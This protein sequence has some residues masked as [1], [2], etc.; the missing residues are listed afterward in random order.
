MSR[1]VLVLLLIAVGL[2]LYLWLVEMPTEQKRVETATATKK[3]VNF[4]E[5]DV[6]ALTIISSQGEVELTR[7]KDDRWIINKPKTME[8]ETTAVEELLRT[9]L[10]ANVSRVVDESGMDLDRL[11]PFGLRNP[12]SPVRRFRSA[13]FDRLCDAGGFPQSPPHQPRASGSLHQGRS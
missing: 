8:A 9:L 10:L 3:L 2:G 5:E 13:L 12:D 11:L 1:G 4:Q 6:Q 7:E